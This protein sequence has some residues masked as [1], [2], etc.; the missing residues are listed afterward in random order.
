M[1]IEVGII[2]SRIL[3]NI[4]DDV[5]EELRSQLSYDVQGAYF[6]RMHSKKN[7][8]MWDGKQYLINAQNIFYTGFLPR[9]KGILD[10]FK[11]KYETRDMRGYSIDRLPFKLRDYQED[12]LVT[13]IREKRGILYMV[14]R[15]GKTIIDI[16]STLILKPYP[17]VFFCRSLDIAYQTI[18]KYKEFA[19]S[20]N[21]GLIGDGNVNIEDVTLVT[22]QSAVSAYGEKYKWKKGE[23]KEKP[24]IKKER[25]NVQYLIEKARF[26]TYDEAHHVSSSVSQFLF[27]RILSAEYVIGLSGTPWREDNTDLLLEGLIGP[28][29]YEASYSFLIKRGYLVAPTIYFVMVPPMHFPKKVSYSAVYKDYIVENTV[30]NVYV[31]RVAEGL[32]KKG[33]LVLVVVREIKHGK[34]LSEMI[35]DSVWLYGE[36]KTSRRNEVWNDFRNKK[37]GILITTLADEGMDIPRLGVVVNAAGSKSSTLAHQ[38]LRMLTPYKNKDKA[39]FVDFLDDAPY[40]S[41]HSK[42]KIKLYKR[43]EEFKVIIKE[44]F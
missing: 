3:G 42:S 8:S 44:D 9:V 17:K 33:F 13:L 32:L 15:S 5:K 16:A 1:K 24:V 29:I 39:I 34:I 26:V 4:P 27:D 23:K 21:V 12:A 41:T 40:L 19:P 2:K 30:R 6:I 35:S 20:V 18:E 38:R 25:K 11:C 31:K 22:I 7:L 36:D 14:P 28:I 10:S 37:I 43:E